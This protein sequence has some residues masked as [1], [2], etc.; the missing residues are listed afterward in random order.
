M[1]RGLG[2]SLRLVPAAA[3]LVLL[4]RTAYTGVPDPWRPYLL[5]LVGLSALYGAI[6]WFTASDELSGRPFWIL[7]MIA[8]VVASAVCGVPEASLAWGLACIFSG[9]LLFLLSAR[10]PQLAS[11]ASFWVVRIYRAAFHACLGWYAAI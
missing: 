6:L 5:A 10:H 2:T 3:S 1:R 4:V 11:S 7:G 8:F 9:G